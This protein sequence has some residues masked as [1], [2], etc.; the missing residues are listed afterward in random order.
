[1]LYVAVRAARRAGDI[2]ARAFDDRE[3]IAV[4][5][6]KD[7]DFVTEIDQQAEQCI[8][9]EIKRHYPKHTIIAEESGVMNAGN[10]TCWYIDPLDGTTNFIHGYPHFAVSIAVWSNGSPKFAVVHDPMRNETFEAENGNGA[11]LNRRRLRVSDEL[12]VSRSLF[13][14]G[15]PPYR[16]E[17]LPIF[18]K[19]MD[20]C[21]QHADGYRRGGSAAL[22]LAYIAAG[23]ID[24]YW[25][26]G[27]SSW[28]I[29]AGI[30][31]VQEA[32]GM[33]TGLDGAAVDLEKGDV[34]AANPT[35]HTA[36]Q[37]LIQ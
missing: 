3:N 5:E 2:I 29:A 1:M 23:R 16:R 26:A 7:R 19:R 13:A 36:Y 11:L 20:I 27:L 22:D 35:L 34:L 37:S 32:G 21:M 10:S 25:E 31:L 24:A 18:Q 8:I 17:D 28:D 6:K 4:R 33:V 9:R 30:I 12:E 15:L 14:S